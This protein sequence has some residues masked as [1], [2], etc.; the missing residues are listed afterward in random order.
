[1]KLKNIIISV[2]S[3]ICLV[4]ASAYLLFLFYL[5]SVLNSPEYVL[6]YENFL[7]SKAGF[8]V[9]IDNFKLKTN[10]DFSLNVKVKGIEATNLKKE[11]LIE[12]KNIDFLTKSFS[13]KP[14][15]L[16]ADYIFVDYNLLK[17]NLKHNDNQS[18]INLKF[19]YLPIINVK[20]AY[21]KLDDKNSSISV[22]YIKSFTQKNKIICKFLAFV[23]IPYMKKPVIIGENG[24]LF[25]SKEL[26]FD[27]LS[28]KFGN[29]KIYLK[30]TTNKLGIRGKNLPV[31]ELEQNF[32]YF[33][34]LKHPNK[35][36]FIE[37]F[38]NFG[39]T[40]DI[41][42]HLAGGK[43][44]GKCMANNLYALFSNFYI[45]VSLPYTVFN[46]ENK[47]I[48][49]KTKGTFGKEPVYTDFYL[50][51]LATKNLDVKGNVRSGLTNKFAKKYY[52]AVVISGTGLAEVKY[53][54]HKG[55]SDILY[56]LTVNKGDNLISKYGSIDMV[57]RCRKISA[58]THK[59]G[60]NI[61]LK[62]Y[63]YSL[64]NGKNS[65]ILLS[66]NGLFKKIDKHYKPV[67]MT[68][69]TNGRIPV[70]VI[71]SF[72][73]N[74][75]Y[76]GTFSADLKYNCLLKLLTGDVNLYDTKHDDYL[77]LKTT[78]IKIF[79]DRISANA[80]G[81]FINSPITISI[82]AD[83]NFSNR[84]LIYKAYI[85]LKKFIV[86]R[87]EIENLPV[88]IASKS[89]IKSSKKNKI[90]V[91]S[92]KIKVDEIVHSKFYL[93][94]VEI[95]GSFRDN[96]ANF[97]IPG[98]K[99]A[100]GLLSAVGEYDISNHSSDINFL[101][102]D[103]DSNE[104]VT[105]IFKLPNQIQGSA[106]A[107][108]H[109]ITK[110]KL[111]DINALAT[112]AI[113]DGFLPKLG[114]TEFFID[115]SKHKKL[116]RNHRFTLSKISNIDFSK[117]N[118]FYSNLRGTFIL[119]NSDVEKIKIF[120][121]SDYLSLFI[122]GKYNIDSGL[123]DLCVWG[124]HNKTHEKK[125]RIFKI[126]LNLLYKMFFRVEHSK[127]LYASEISMIPPIKIK[128]TDIESIFRV[129]VKGILNTDNVKVILKDLK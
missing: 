114:S 10:P 58:F 57:D 100:N 52:P 25:Y 34:K 2:T 50:T 7:S 63:N 98:T 4:F 103:I 128:A 46:F 32:L 121:Q 29:S 78:N 6:K 81:T 55:I 41:N 85:H 83:N 76:K 112:F 30:G 59:K 19:D 35:K 82:D 89:N 124:R 71:Q 75:I 8:P 116:H 84:I 123:A 23:K 49:A 65:Q 91:Q 118:M 47:K 39:G 122:N 26:N 11:K 111:N 36:N 13:V 64:V 125:I 117:P 72:T 28:L 73:K 104:V 3:I 17:M 66:G 27:N 9:H 108:L 24:S 31:S 109:L 101:A 88:G 21:I 42:L 61:Y 1:M 40:L 38:K 110:R 90:I 126:P 107:T 113:T 44:Y 119:N 56:S 33:Y 99:Y 60:D 129:S 93:S 79:K 48:T 69:K 15:T 20:K 37:N 70:S 96:I 92:G 115:K 53:H 74:F 54:T 68:L 22:N 5:P 127:S 43:I 105:N 45:P 106:Y 62:N 97:I 95:F 87:G 16:D 77:F 102:S 86:K 18:K 12:V 80:D 51:G 14:K 120:S 67:N 94:D